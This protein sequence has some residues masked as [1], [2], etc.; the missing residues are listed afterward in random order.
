MKKIFF[1]ILFFSINILTFGANVFF[2]NDGAGYL[3]TDGQ[4]FYSN[5][6]GHALV[7]Y[8]IWADPLRYSV[9]KWGAQFQTPDGTWGT[10]SELTNGGYGV[11]EC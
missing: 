8:H 7:Y 6:D 5:S 10:W 11:H 4:I 1:L 3:Y 2:I 9:S